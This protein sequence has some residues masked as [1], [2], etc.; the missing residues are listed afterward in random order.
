MSF[1]GPWPAKVPPTVT[2][3]PPIQL[4]L[5]IPTTPSHMAVERLKSIVTTSHNPKPICRCP[6]A[7]QLLR[8][9]HKKISALPKDTKEAGDDHPLAGFSGDPTGAVEDG[10]DAW[11]KWDGPL[12]A[13]LQKN[14]T[15]WW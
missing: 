3:P 9:L 14:W 2:N 5:F 11:E 8:S 13:L 4:T 7:H 15:S 12:N 10:K 1:F 6:I